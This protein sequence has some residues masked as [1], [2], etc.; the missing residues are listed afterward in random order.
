MSI[1]SF[2]LNTLVNEDSGCNG[3]ESNYIYYPPAGNLT[4][5]LQRGKSYSFSLQSSPAYP[6][7]FG[8]WLDYNN[9]GD[10]DDAGE[11][12]YNSD[13]AGMGV[14]TGSL[15]IPTGTGNGLRRLR[16]RSTYNSTFTSAESCTASDYGETEDYSITIGESIPVQWN[17]RFGGSQN[18]GLTTV[19]KTSD[20]GYLVGGYSASGVSGDKSQAG[21]GKNDYW[22]VKTDAAGNKLWDKT[23]GGAENEYLNRVIQTQDGGYLLAGS[24]LSGTSGNKTQSSRGSR[25]YWLVK[26]DASGIKQWD[27]RYGGKGEDELK[28]VLQLTTGEYILAGHSNSP[29]GDDKS[30][31][32]QGGWDYWLVKVSIDGV[33]LWDKRYGG[34]L[35]ETLGGIVQ[36]N[37]GGFLLGGSS[38]SGI[39]GDKSAFSRGGTDFWL[40]RTDDNGNMLWDK[41]YG[42]SGQDLVLSV[43]KSGKS[44][45]FISGQ[46]DSPAGW[47]KT[48][49]NHG[50]IDYW[51]IKVTS[52]GEKVWD[53][54]FGGTKDDELRASIQTT[55]GG[56]LLAGKSFSNRSGN[57]RQNS[58]GSSDFWIVKTDPDGMYQ[59]DRR[60]GGSGTEEL[61]A[62]LQT[63][64]GGLLLAGKSD[65]EASGEKT[66]PSQGGNDY[67]LVKVALEA[68]SIMAETTKEA[69]LGE[70]SAV[71]TERTMFQASPNP[72]Q[73]QVTVRFTLPEAQ[74][75]QVKIYDIQGRDIATLFHG[76]AKANQIYQLKWNA[77]NH[78]TGMYLLQ[79]QTA[80]KCK[81]QK[82]L[83]LR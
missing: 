12:I 67:W 82:I 54:R 74:S 30:Q 10:F 27:K 77:A 42:G 66:Q 55:D 39:S 68:T 80:G 22:I 36:V 9:D 31:G 4:T 5:R 61:R 18:E 56:Y 53:K 72:F 52:T 28:K 41:T 19:I 49:D 37:G 57:K 79:L 35:D 8:I 23:Y 71:A 45:F 7:G 58:R 69:T 63:S 26:V 75:A 1:Q 16:V 65:S 48:R 76:E 24:S 78:V 83:L 20:G 62:V 11:F 43:G 59:W 17:K 21:Q 14:F 29:A 33:K 32:S 51:F 81:Q 13:A 60:Y 73:E 50:G 6:Q 40:V 38:A 46:S 44:D 3:Q 70:Q 64:D 47:D 15:T 34:N 2:R 25:D